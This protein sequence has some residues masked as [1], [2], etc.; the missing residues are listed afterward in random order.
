MCKLQECGNPLFFR[1]KHDGVLR[2]NRPFCA[3]DFEAR[4]FEIVLY[5]EAGAFRHCDQCHDNLTS[6]FHHDEDG[7][8][9]LMCIICGRQY[10][11]RPIELVRISG[12]P[13][14]A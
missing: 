11:V 5:S 8:N 4:K 7:H 6:A 2:F 1:S 10:L 13:C 14:C 12:R 3:Q 9:I